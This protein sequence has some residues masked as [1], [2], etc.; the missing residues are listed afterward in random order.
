V[1]RS[2]G[3]DELER[4]RE[5]YASAAW[6][7]AYE[8][9]S[10]ADQLS[11]LAAQDLELL[12]TSAYM[13]GRED[14]WMRILERAHHGH[15]E[16]R[17]NRRAVRCAFWIGIVLAIRGEMGAATG[18]LGRAQRLL[19]REQGECVEQ[20]YL[21]MPVVFQHEAEGDWEGASATAAAAAET[22]E[23]FG[24]ADLFAPSRYAQGDILVRTA[25]LKGPQPARRSDGHGHAELVSPVVA[26]SS[27]AA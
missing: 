13:L 11:P 5:S 9:L 2:A 4:G 19:E 23:R 12:A 8:S 16:A 26:G 14:E 24:D 21:L 10:R 25:G 1:G 17:E 22:A 6:S 15:S 27:I 20:G 7:T 18:W 3:D